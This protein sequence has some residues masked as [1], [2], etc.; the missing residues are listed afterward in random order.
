MTQAVNSLNYYFTEKASFT[1]LSKS[2]K[3]ALVAISAL[4]TLGMILSFCLSAPWYITVGFFLLSLS[5]LF[6]LGKLF[7]NTIVIKT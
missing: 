4:F 1:E 3:V 2:S 6:P 7:N 5:P